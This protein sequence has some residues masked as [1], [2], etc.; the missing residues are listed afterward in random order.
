MCVKHEFYIVTKNEEF[1]LK[2]K[3]I[4]VNRFLNPEKSATEFLENSSIT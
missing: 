4:Y 2:K 3:T 1:F